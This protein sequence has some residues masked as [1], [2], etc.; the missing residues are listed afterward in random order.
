MFRFMLHH[1]PINMIRANITP[2]LHQ[3]KA[4]LIAPHLNSWTFPFELDGHIICHNHRI[5]YRL[6][7]SGPTICLT[8]RDVQHFHFVHS[9]QARSHKKLSGIILDRTIQKFVTV[10]LTNRTHGSAINKQ[11]TY[12]KYGHIP[13]C[14]VCLWAPEL[15]ILLQRPFVNGT[16]WNL[17]KSSRQSFAGCSHPKSKL[18]CYFPFSP[19]T[20]GKNN[21]RFEHPS[22]TILAPLTSYIP[23]GMWRFQGYSRRTGEGHL[24]TAHINICTTHTLWEYKNQTE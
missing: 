16:V 6:L 10:I 4:E 14:P 1:K 15:S 19:S 2:S 11:V 22:L 9:K 17:C 24:L 8:F 13:S 3:N 7:H 18:G 12:T 20:S 5:C 21:A 23:Q